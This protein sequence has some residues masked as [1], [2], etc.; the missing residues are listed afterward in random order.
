MAA[1]RRQIRR[2]IRHE[3]QSQSP[4]ARQACHGQRR[5]SRL[6]QERLLKAVRKFSTFL[7]NELV[8]NNLHNFGLRKEL[9]HLAA[10]RATFKTITDRFVFYLA[11]W[12]NVRDDF[13]LLQRLAR[14]ITLVVALTAGDSWLEKGANLLPFG[15]T[16]PDS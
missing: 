7:R 10:V 9:D 6:L 3:A 11:E 1:G 13:P 5:L 2:H 4:H 8:S 15:P 16:E 12:L 14:P